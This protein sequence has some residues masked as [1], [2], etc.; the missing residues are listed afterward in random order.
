MSMTTASS[1]RLKVSVNGWKNRRSVIVEDDRVLME[2]A[3]TSN[4]CHHCPTC[5]RRVDTVEQ[6][7]AGE[8]IV[9]KWE[10]LAEGGMWLALARVDGQD[11]IQLLREATGL[12][13]GS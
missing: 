10:F 5:R 2:I 8:T 9:W 3:R 12:R 7:L 6:H 4:N 11:P 1:D 13:I